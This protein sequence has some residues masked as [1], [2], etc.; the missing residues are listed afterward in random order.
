MDHGL[1]CQ[2]QLGCHIKQGA[3]LGRGIGTLKRG[4]IV[5]AFLG[6]II[7]KHLTDSKI[8]NLD[9]IILRHQEIRRLDISMDNKRRLPCVQIGQSF[10]NIHNK[11]DLGMDRCPWMLFKK[12]G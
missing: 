6:P 10:G 9:M 12:F 2:N 11:R 5:V 3:Y 7:G 8:G 1:S 4:K